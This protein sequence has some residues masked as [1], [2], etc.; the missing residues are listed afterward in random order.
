MATRTI[1]LDRNDLDKSIEVL[2]SAKTLQPTRFQRLSYRALII[3]VDV[4]AICY[5][6]YW[7]NDIFNHYDPDNPDVRP[8]VVAPLLIAFMAILVAL[9]ALALNIPLFLRAF[10]ERTRLK[11]LGLSSLTKSLWKESR[12]N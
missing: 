8:I 11:E 12:R 6:A 2:S 7:V 4:A 5:L 3:S 1:D 10:R 9:V